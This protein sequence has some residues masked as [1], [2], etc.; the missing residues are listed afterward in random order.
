MLYMAVDVIK[1]G[2]VVGYL[3]NNKSEKFAMVLI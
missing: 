1:K 2:K 3:M